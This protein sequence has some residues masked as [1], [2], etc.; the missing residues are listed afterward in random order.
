MRLTRPVLAAGLAL[1]AAGLTPAH[2][3]G[4]TIVKT[5]NFRDATPDPT[6]NAADSDDMHCHGKLPDTEKPIVFK[7]PRAGVLTVDLGKFT[8]DWAL[9]IRDAKDNQ[10]TG[11]EANPPSYESATL[12]VKKPMTL[13]IKPCNLSGTFDATVKVT[14]KIK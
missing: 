3:G 9:E 14:F 6:G 2:A 8:G 4:K 1:A 5:Y 7:A 10:L 11:A 12:R 13:H